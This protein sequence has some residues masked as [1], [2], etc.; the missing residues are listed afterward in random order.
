MIRPL[1]RRLEYL[2]QIV[3][4][5]TNKN[6]ALRAAVD[7][8]RWNI[9]R[10]LI[11]AE[12]L[13]EISD[14]VQIIISN[15]ENYATLAY[16]NRLYDFREMMFLV[17][18]LR[19]N[20]LFVDVGA[21]I[22]I[23]TI[24]AS[25]VAGADSLA[26]EPVPST[27]RKLIRNIRLNNVQNKAEAMRKG[28]SDRAGQ[29]NITTE[30]GGLNHVVPSTDNSASMTVDFESLDSLLSGKTIKMMKIDVEGYEMNV[31]RGGRDTL[32]DPSLQALIVELNG[33]GGRYGVT[34]HEVHDEIVSHGFR[35]FT[36]EPEQRRLVEAPTFNMDDYNTLYCRIDKEMLDRVRSA[37]KV[38]V[39]DTLI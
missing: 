10:R 39:R 28:I 25:A 8:L 1:I 11:D 22:G 9:G 21:G 32:S 34:D 7:Y 18:F 23:Y 16:A 5:P 31:L 3:S 38:R 13:V 29:L 35:P 37:Q 2:N 14:T 20:D 36:Y 12:Y 15:E 27:H 26:F 24:L 30:L 17:H 4:H 19:G 6:R 33:S